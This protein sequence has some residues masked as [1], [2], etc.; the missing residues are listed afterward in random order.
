VD[1][2]KPLELTVKA[3]PVVKAKR[4]RTVDLNLA[5]M[6]GE[7]LVQTVNGRPSMGNPELGRLWA[8]PGNLEVCEDSERKFAP[9][10]TEYL[11]LSLPVPLSVRPSLCLLLSL[12]SCNTLVTLL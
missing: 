12:Y 2:S 9:N 3:V 1:L 10:L 5:A 7:Q 8:L 11:P 4:S 6:A